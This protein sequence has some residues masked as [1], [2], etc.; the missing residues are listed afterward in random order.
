MEAVHAVF[1]IF[2][3]SPLAICVERF[4]SGGVTT[5]ATAYERRIERRVSGTA[6]HGE[7]GMAVRC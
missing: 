4:E 2:V 7:A 1:I 3:D 5:H 6:V